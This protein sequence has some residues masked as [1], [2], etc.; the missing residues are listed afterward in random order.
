MR[1]RE[2]KRE[3]ERERKRGI[4]SRISFRTFIRLKSSDRCTKRGVPPPMKPGWGGGVNFAA[5]II[6]MRKSTVLP[7][8]TGVK[9]EVKHSD[10]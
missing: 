3:K 4:K 6:H 9:S 1:G 10:I 5:R 7:S 2:K 8:T